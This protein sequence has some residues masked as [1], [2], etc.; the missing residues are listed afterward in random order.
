M[1]ILLHM[2]LW[3]RFTNVLVQ[4]SSTFDL[5]ISIV[6][7]IATVSAVVAILRK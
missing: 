4:S 5:I 1:H 2:G 7:I 6:A 3:H